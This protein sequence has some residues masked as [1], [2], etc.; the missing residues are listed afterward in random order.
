[1]PAWY[2]F[3]RPSHYAFHDLR[4]DKTTTIIPKNIHTLLGLGLKFCPTPRNTS[5]K[6]DIKLSL[7]RNQRDIWLRHYFKKKDAALMEDYNPRLYLKSRWTPPDWE[8]HN[9]LKRRFK[10]FS[11][12]LLLSF[13]TKKGSSNLLDN[14]RQA[15]QS[16]L[17][18][19]DI[20]IAQCDKNLGPA[21]IE[22]TQYIKMAFRDHLD[23]TTTYRYLSPL[24]VPI[25]CDKIRSA[26]KKWLEKWKSQLPTHEHKF[27]KAATNDPKAD[28]IATFYLTM[29][30]HKTPLKTRPIVSCSGTLLY[31]LG[32]WIDD[33]LQRIASIQQSYFKSSFVLQA[34]LVQLTNLSNI[35]LFTADAVSMYT[36]INTNK[37]IT[38]ISKYLRDNEHLFMDIPINALIEALSLTMKNNIF[39]FGDTTWLQLTGTAMGTP[40]APAYATLYYAIHED[41][42]LRE[43]GSNLSLYRRFIDDIIGLWKVTD[44]STD[45][46]TWQHFQ[47]RLNDFDL[48]WEVSKRQ[49]TVNFMD[50]TIKLDQRR[51][52]T[53]L[54]EKIQN[55][56]LYIPPH[57]A[58]P[59]GVLTG[60]IFGNTYRIYKLCSDKSD[61]ERLIQQ[62]YRRLLVRGYKTAHILP[63]FHKAALRA[64]PNAS[65]HTKPKP[66]LSDMLFLHMQY[67][68]NDP[69]SRSIQSLW[70]NVMLQPTYKKHLQT[71]TN[72]KRLIIAYSRPRNLGNL[73]SSRIIRTHN[74]PPV[75]SYR[76]TNQEGTQERERDRERGERAHAPSIVKEPRVSSS[77]MFSRF[78]FK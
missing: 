8:I 45:E 53:T 58:H 27:I 52:T 67:H 51:I 75:S 41:N 38:I 74:G 12:K 26:L 22:T 32:I 29:K 43:F 25:M 70:K 39:R 61:Q 56:Y 50:L 72:T 42:I 21:C 63:L 71:F 15:L 35:S 7:Q 55:P 62:F 14:Q 59:P 6:N 49:P 23:D 46:T 44:P 11:S 33:K 9:E 68:P 73:L 30:V 24:I 31:P 16:L 77:N 37:A 65:V 48:E 2:Y 36:N 19:P 3:A 4:I 10:E 1:M 13:S 54:Y 34:E 60:L 66:S 47:S 76:I 69:P 40:P 64:R 28:P 18:S 78:S 17:A 20:I 5:T 57:S